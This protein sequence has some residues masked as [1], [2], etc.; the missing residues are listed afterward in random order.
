MEMP[1]RPKSV[2]PN[3]RYEARRDAQWEVLRA[4]RAFLGRPLELDDLSKIRRAQEAARQ[5]ERQSAPAPAA[6]S[7]SA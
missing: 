1:R 7:T 4:A 5:T 2:S 3:E 6:V